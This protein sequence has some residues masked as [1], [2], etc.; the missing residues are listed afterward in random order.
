MSQESMDVRYVGFKPMKTDTVCGTLATW[1]G[2]GDVQTVEKH[3]GV[4]LIRYPTVWQL[5]SL[6]FKPQKAPPIVRAPPA[7]IA[8]DD[9][10]ETDGEA[11]VDAID[12]AADPAAEVPAT[13][14]EI[15]KAIEGLDRDADFTDMG[16]PKID[17]VRAALPGKSVT[18][19][20]VGDAWKTFSGE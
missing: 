19:K 7:I 2:H 12:Q 5:A 16:R 4:L 9:D 8:E 3:I 14:G 18:T 1:I 6:P 17:A 15:V 13:V 20:A 11:D 10:D